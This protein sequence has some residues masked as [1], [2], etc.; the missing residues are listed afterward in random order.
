MHT[1]VR[2][3]C[4]TFLVRSTAEAATLV[5]VL[6]EA[7]KLRCHFAEH[8]MVFWPDKDQTNIHVERVGADQL[9]ARDTKDAEPADGETAVWMSP[10]RPA[11]RRIN[12]HRNQLFLGQ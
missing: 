8:R 9:L 12:G 6:G 3:G 10:P 5:R 7:V 11:R 2:V 1:V 4:E